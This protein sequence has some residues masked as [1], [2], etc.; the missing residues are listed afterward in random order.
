VGGE[1]RGNY[2]TWNPLQSSAA[3]LTNGNLD[4]TT[5]TATGGQ[6][7]ATIAVSSGKWYWEVTVNT[8]VTANNI[9]IIKTSE[10]LAADD[11]SYLA[12]GYSYYRSTGDKRNNASASAYGAT[13][14]SGDVIGVALDLDA[15]TL[16]FYK[17]GASQGT[18]FS[19]LTG[20]FIPCV[21]D[22]TGSNG[23]D[24]TTNFGQRAFVYTAPSGFK[25][26][27]DTNLGAPLVAKPNTLMDVVKYDGNGSTQTISGLAF[28]PDLVWLKGRSLTSNHRLYDQI[29]GATKS[30]YSDLTDPEG[31]EST[32]LTAFTSDGF[33]LGDQAGHNQNASTYVAWAWD[34]GTTTDPSNQ[35]GSITSQVR[36]NVS[37]GF[38]VVT[39]TG[40][41]GNQSF[42]HGLGVKPKLIMIKNRSNSANWF[43]MFDIGTTYYKYGHL[44]TTD[45]FYD[46]TAQPVTSTTIT[47]GSNN[48]WFGAVGDNYVAYCFA[49]VVGY[50]SMGSYVASSGLPYVYLGFR[51]R[52]VLIKNI[53]TS[54]TG[55]RII[56]SAR[57]SFNDGAGAYWL[58]AQSSGAEVDERPVDLLS[59]GFKLRMTDG[60]DL[61]Y[62]SDTYIYYAVAENPFQYARAR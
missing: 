13:Y 5:A 31:T 4:C 39:Y 44:N 30:I 41:A 52:F 12:G 38:S 8:T 28:E 55:W 26:L 19:S 18:A 50:S 45:Q 15:G 9:G 47:Y 40:V 36:A 2:A 6:V 53:T 43:V 22:G 21:G 16:V 54:S 10:A 24:M 11:P 33:S 29:R 14:G 61:N 23:L 42:G 56:D 62:S 48:A 51:P 32:G 35:A 46:A 3:T 17:N 60:G 27:C 25:A 49:P 7:R 1:V 58:S 20:E 57:D 37:A 34:A 59:N